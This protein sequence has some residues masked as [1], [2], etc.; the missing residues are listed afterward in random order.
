[1]NCQPGD[2]AF[3]VAPYLDLAMRGLPVKVVRA[4]DGRS[5]VVSKSGD[6]SCGRGRPC[7]LVDGNDSR[8]PMV[9]ADQYLRPIRDPGD[10][11]VDEMVLRKMVPLPTIKPELIPERARA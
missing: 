7:W 5:L 1:M 2:L 3:I 9:I 8:L 11:A 10:D 4:D 6:L